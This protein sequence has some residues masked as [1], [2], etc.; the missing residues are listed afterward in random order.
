MDSIGLRLVRSLLDVKE[1]STVTEFYI[2]A[3][4]LYG[5]AKTSYEWVMSHVRKYGSWPNAKMVEEN[6][7]VVL[8]DESDKIKYVCDLVR[9][10]TLGKGLEKDLRLAAELLESRD[11]DEA[12]TLMG[13]AALRHRK[14]SLRASV[15]SY[16]DSSKT[17]LANYESLKTLG[18]Y[19]GVSTPWD[20]LDK[21]IQG[22]VNGT[23][24]V[25]TGMQNTGKTWFL[26]VCANH[27][28]SLDK[29]IIFVTLEMTSDRIAKRLDSIHYK[30]PFRGLRDGDLDVATEERWKE[31][32]KRDSE[33]PG[34]ILFADKQLIRTVD[35]AA[36]IV[37]EYKPD[38]IF[39]DA[40]YRFQTRGS[41]GNWEQQVEIIRNL[42]ISAESTNIPWVVSTQ[43]GDSSETGKES[44]RGPHM[45]AWNVRYG[46]EWVIDPDVVLGLYAND[47][48]R[49]LK[50]ME[51][52]CLKMRDN[53]GDFKSTFK[54][55]WDTTSM[56]FTESLLPEFSEFSTDG[57]EDAVSF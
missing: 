11:P 46:K 45:R 18:G 21:C 52:H 47:D 55:N 36:S 33:K 4:D 41:K 39:I 6:C 48:L 24:N 42:Q 1:T 49:L 19:R 12:L 14:R 57:L 32:V 17:R 38:I 2:D 20:S 16:K 44:K 9:K 26:G 28:L 34:D 27:A 3:N 5:E 22:W 25:V 40:G 31:E 15:V 37:L 54:I 30:M 51:V 7:S 29:K 23:L 56:D 10:R 8:P 50:Q 53:A 13:D 35:D 43:Q